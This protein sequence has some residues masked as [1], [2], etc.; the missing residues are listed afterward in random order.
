MTDD[1]GLRPG[2]LILALMNTKSVIDG[3]SF[4]VSLYPVDMSLMA[5][6]VLSK[7]RR[8]VQS[9][10]LVL[11]FV[12]DVTASRV[13]YFYGGRAFDTNINTWM[14]DPWCGLTR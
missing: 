12:T 8:H 1:D 11:A 5:E 10:E 9:Y 3:G 14:Y 6:V 7:M 13:K 4:I 2:M